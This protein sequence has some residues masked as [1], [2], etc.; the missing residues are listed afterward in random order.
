MVWSKITNKHEQYIAQSL[1]VE[2]LSGQGILVGLT[3]SSDTPFVSN[4]T[5]SVK[6]T[7]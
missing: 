7:K 2:E 3:K 5:L 1:I 6:L 4:A